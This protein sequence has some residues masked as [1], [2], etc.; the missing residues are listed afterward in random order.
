MQVLY[1]SANRSPRSS[2]RPRAKHNQG[3]IP[4]CS[5][6]HAHPTNST[7]RA[8]EVRISPGDLRAPLQWRRR[9]HLVRELRLLV[10]R[11]ASRAQGRASGRSCPA[12]VRSSMQ[13]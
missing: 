4:T 13:F 3:V 9:L 6:A 11:A 2:D 7:D 10:A 5:H 1:S 8:D 12:A